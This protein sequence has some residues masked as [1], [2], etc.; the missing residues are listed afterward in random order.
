MVMPGSSPTIQ[1]GGN[2]EGSIVIGDNNFVVNNNHGTIVYK[3]AQPQ[4][5]LRSMAPRPP[6]APRTFTGRERELAALNDLIA[7]R[8]P[9]L[10]TGADGI[11]KSYLLKRVAN[12]EAAQEL[13]N[14]VVF[15][16][17]IDPSGTALAW[18]DLQQLL[19][20]ALF[21][22]DPPL[23]VTF[24]S[25]RTYLSNTSPLVL[26]D[27]VHIPA[28][29]MDNLAD[30]FP[31]APILAVPTSAPDSE[32]FEPFKVDLLAMPD[33]IEL[34]AARAKIDLAEA[35]TAV[36]EKVCT[37]LNRLPLAIATVGNAMRENELTLEQAVSALEMIQPVATQPNKAAIE[38]SLRFADAF[39]SDDERQMAGLAAAA[40]AVSTSR[41]WLENASGGSAA[42]QKLENLGLLQANSP[43]LRLHGEYAALALESFDPN[44]MKGRM[45]ASLLELLETR[46]LDF[47]FVKEELG[48]ILGLLKWAAGQQRWREVFALVRAVDPF[49]TLRGLWSAWGEVLGLGRS[50]AIALQDGPGEAWALHQMGTQRIGV[51]ELQEAVD[52]L[53]Q[54]LRQRIALGDQTGAAFTRHNLNLLGFSADGD[55]EGPD[56]QPPEPETQAVDGKKV[57]S[58]RGR[59]ALITSLVVLTAI[60]ALGGLVYIGWI[61]LPP[62][63]N[64]PGIN[65]NAPVV[66]A[67][68]QDS[69]TPTSAPTFTP[70]ATSTPTET[71]SPSPSPTITPT[72]TPRPSSTPSPTASQTA[73]PTE[74]LTPSETA[75]NFP[76]FI[77]S[78]GQANCRYGPATAYLYANG[79]Y[80]GDT[81]EVRGRNRASTWFLLRLDKDGTWCWAA[82]DTLTIR[83]DPA[84]VDVTQ[85]NLPHTTDTSA[86]TNVSAVRNGPQVTITW[87]QVHINLV[88]ARGYL[89]DV[90]ICQNTLRIPYII[91]TDEVS[92]TFTDEQNCS[93]PSSGRIYA[94]NKR[95]YTDPVV[96]PWP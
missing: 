4:V 1:V 31:Q 33:A 13:P 36:L 87:D 49:L 24:A 94:V 58:L 3:E 47:T 52:L 73:T 81:G 18:D 44:E 35:D 84:T 83:G 75:F 70:T 14:G 51:G 53:R 11:G 23:K 74:A 7:D 72:R 88:D 16:E 56:D 90:T 67:A 57:R 96:I 64:L 40:P 37:L 85:P 19:F 38:R 93:R 91:Q 6:R 61:K 32:V 42:S 59:I 26:L 25:A 92:Y 82:G 95:G 9:V 54:A 30:L 77:V 89:L 22:S 8:A 20:D 12:E 28:D 45:L 60:A 15:L 29:A 79:L 2:V 34:L 41:V 43:R 5:R 17:G 65:S 71:S 27:N 66:Q 76:G 10:M 86:P 21:E 68:L 62:G 69:P 46:S 80:S 63:L 50:A 48:N 78:V 39:L 55:Q